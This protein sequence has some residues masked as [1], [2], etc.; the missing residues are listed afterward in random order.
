MDTHRTIPRKKKVSTTTTCVFL[1]LTPSFWTTNCWNFHGIPL[2]VKDCNRAIISMTLR[3]Q[4]HSLT[5]IDI[6]WHSLTSKYDPMFM[7]ID[8]L[9]SPWMMFDCFQE[10]AAGVFSNK[11]A[12]DNGVPRVNFSVY[13]YNMRCCTR[14]FKKLEGLKASTNLWFDHDFL[15]CQSPKDALREWQG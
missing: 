13:I 9:W 5:F 11:S 2:A 8:D 6:H 12:I 3:S 7:T 15:T 1:F 4:W 10:S 14:D